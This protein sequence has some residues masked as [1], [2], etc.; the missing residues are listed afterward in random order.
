[1]FPLLSLPLVLFLALLSL[2]LR[3]VLSSLELLLSLL[4]LVLAGADGV[5]ELP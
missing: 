4:E 1:M 5:G 3:L 2:P